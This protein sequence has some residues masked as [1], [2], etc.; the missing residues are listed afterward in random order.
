[1]KLAPG[2]YSLGQHA[3]IHAEQQREV[4]IRLHVLRF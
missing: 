1:M 2:F 3:F 4:A